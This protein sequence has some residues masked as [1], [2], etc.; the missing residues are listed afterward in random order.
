[1]SLPWAL[2][3][4]PPPIKSVEIHGTK[5]VLQE[6]RLV[7]VLLQS[8]LACAWAALAPIPGAPLGSRHHIA[9]WSALSLAMDEFRDLALLLLQALWTKSVL[10]PRTL[11]MRRCY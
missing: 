11:A 5:I 1:M 8:A 7:G 9:A 4:S 2:P 10:L 6:D 3:M